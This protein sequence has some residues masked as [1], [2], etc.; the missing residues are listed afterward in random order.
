MHQGDPREQPSR[1]VL[2]APLSSFAWGTGAQHLDPDL[3][4]LH[5]AGELPPEQALAAAAHL[6]VCEDGRCGALMRD[7]AA[8]LDGIARSIFEVEPE[9]HGKPETPGLAARSFECRDGLWEAFEQMA[10]EAGRT[11]DD[12]LNEA[13][14]VHLSSRSYTLPPAEV[15]DA[16]RAV[17]APSSQQ[18]ATPPPPQRG[19]SG[20]RPPLPPPPPPRATPPPLPPQTGSQPYGAPPPPP[21]GQPSYGGGP[22]PPP[23][24]PQRGAPPLPPPPGQPS[25]GG[26]PPP[27]PPPQRGAAPPP[28]P[29][30]SSYSAPPGQPTYGGPPPPPPPRQG[31]PPPFGGPPLGPPPFGGPPPPLPPAAGGGMPPLVLIHAA[32]RMLVDKDRFV[33]GRGKQSS[34]FAIKDPNISRQ[35]AIVEFVGGHYY[36][37]DMG[38]TNGVVFAGERVARKHIQEGDRF[39]VGEHEIV[40]SYRT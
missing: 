6:A 21:P 11:V 7:E 36:M 9:P 8:A 13:M 39:M 12:L 18:R 4:A 34:D 24:P 5:V 26:G 40:F 3:V 16:P 29:G 17:P 37:V 35:H 14:E 38:S 32:G 28:P 33:I 31:L 19:V 20:R 30:G 15:P 2:A 10:G 22:P 25:Y 1:R 27:P 23:P